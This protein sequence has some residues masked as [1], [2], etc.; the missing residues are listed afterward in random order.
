MTIILTII[1]LLIILGVVTTIHEFGHFL[2]AK[3]FKIGVEEFSIGFG[4]KLFQFKKKETKYTLRCLPLGGYCAIVGEGEETNREDS[5]KKKPAWQQIIVLAMG[6]I[7]NALLAIV[8]FI[9]VSFSSQTENTVIKE[10]SKNSVAE[11]AGLKVGDEIY[12][13]NGKRVHLYSDLVDT[14]MPQDMTSVNVEYIRDGKKY[15]T[16]IENPITKVGELGI[17][18]VLDEAN[19]TYS[20]KVNMVEAGSAAD[21]AK[22]KDGD[23]IKSVNGIE[24]ANAID[25]V[26]IVKQYPEEEIEL[27]VTRDMEDIVKKVTPKC[28]N[29]FSLGIYS[30]ET[31]KTT[32]SLALYTAKDYVEQIVSSYI[33]LFRGKVSIKQMS[34]IVGVGQVVA[35]TS[36]FL[37]FLKLMA[38]LSMAIGVANILPFPPLDGGKI[39][40]VIIEWI[41]KKKISENVELAISYLGFGLLIA[42]TIFVTYNDITRLL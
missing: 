15:S 3:L 16:I 29:Y 25:V 17:A 30:T 37:Q 42:L 14:N 18:F 40:L 22:I 39:V 20:S 2:M 10:F 9:V 23:I 38:I 19:N 41:T 11:Q 6:V 1:K 12:K 21:N 13:I 34:G 26:Q 36:G 7:F 5:F 32:I 4:P 35:K 27:V 28:I 33:D 24:V 8:L 31:V